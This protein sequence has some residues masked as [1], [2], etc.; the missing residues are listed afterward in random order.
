VQQLKSEETRAASVTHP[1]ADPVTS[2]SAEVREA[3]IGAWVPWVAQ[4]PEP[5]L[6]A[7]ES[8]TDRC[9]GRRRARLRGWKTSVLETLKRLKKDPDSSV[10]AVAAE[11]LAEHMRFAQDDSSD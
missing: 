9:V 5:A 8:P 1:A 6:R 4:D 2:S 10:K 7:A 3:A 11:V